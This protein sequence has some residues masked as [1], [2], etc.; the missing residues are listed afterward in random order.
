M[1]PDPNTQHTK[2]FRTQILLLALILLAFARL[3]WQLD[4]KDFWWDESLTLQR[5]EADWGML[6]RGTLLIKDGFTEMPTTDQHPFLYFV[7]TGMLIRV[8]GISEFAVRFVSVVAAT[9]TVPMVWCIARYLQKRDVAKGSSALW[10]VLF[11]AINP[12]LLWYGQEARPYALWIFLALLCTYCLLR[13]VDCSFPS[14]KVAAA[15]YLFTLFL[16][17]CTQYLSVLLLPVHALLI[18]F[19]LREFAPKLA[20]WA[21]A[22]TIG[23]GAIVGGAVGWI[24]L[25][26]AGAG[27]N[28]FYVSPAILLPDLLNAFSLGL[29]VDIAEV[30][31]VDLLYGAVAL[32]GAVWV[33]RS[34]VV[35]RQRGW[36]VLA[37]VLIPLAAMLLINMVQPA[38][39]N[40]RHMSVLAGGFVLLLGIG[41]GVLW[42]LQKI[43]AALVA[44]LLIGYAG[45]STV[46]YFYAEE[47]NRKYDDFSSLGRFV[48]RRLLP[49]DVVLLRQPDSWRIFE[50]Y[51]PLEQ[52]ER[53]GVP[54]EQATMQTT[55]NRID[56]A[57][58]DAR[59]VWL[60]SSGTTHGFNETDWAAAH[61][62]ETMYRV[63]D[64]SF[65]SI[66]S[67]DA[68][69]Y[70]PTVPVYNEQIEPP[71]AVVDVVFGEQIRLL[72]YEIDEPLTA[73]GAIPVTLTWQTLRQS[74][75][76]Y[77]YI[78]ELAT[79]DGRVLGMT[80][81]EPYDGAIAT[82]FW[83]PAQT[84][85]EYSEV[86]P[87]EPIPPLDQLEIRLQ[88]Y[89]SSTFEK[90]PITYERL[91]LGSGRVEPDVTLILHAKTPQ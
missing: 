83:Q 22:G 65:Y 30:W 21:A 90:L 49:G 68:Q 52:V 28:F 63:Q 57:A 66:S 81:R 85:V 77:K 75:T 3:V 1:V 84:I 6:L 8:A 29:S 11:T 38:Y 44:L 87:T 14:G 18:Y 31:W 26:Q 4:A 76:R 70:L 60:V 33:V 12:F 19:W 39:M 69:I 89:D 61:L 41:L 56:A 35:A 13:L 24:L 67:L 7:L 88:I 10:A 74:K 46:D 16:F 72:A 58:Q 86:P 48:E 2:R 5:A 59:R 79:Q 27:S 50:Y 45:Y 9:A 25:S 55:L 20:V 71:G 15:I 62:Q 64:R 43:V 51:L 80:E 36:V 17:L 82:N 78:V 32:V 47:Y 54:F 73:G 37:F 40:A 34:R 42:R 53:Y 23:L 91:P